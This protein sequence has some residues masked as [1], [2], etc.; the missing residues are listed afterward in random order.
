MSVSEESVDVVTD[1]GSQNIQ[2]ILLRLDLL[3]GSINR[4]LSFAEKIPDNTNTD[5]IETRLNRLDEVWKEFTN[6]T[7][8]LY[9]FKNEK[10]YVDPKDDYYEYEDLYMSA[11]CLLKSAQSKQTDSKKIVDKQAVLIEQLLDRL[12]KLES[13]GNSRRPSREENDFPK[14]V[15]KPF[16]G[17]YNEWPSFETLFTSALETK[18]EWTNI[19]KLKYLK[20][21]LR[22]DAA[23]AIQDIQDSEKSFDIAWKS[24]KQTFHRPRFIANTYIQQF[25]NIPV[26]KKPNSN[27]IRNICGIAGDVLRALDSIGE[28]D[29]DP[30]LIYILLSRLHS[31]LHPKWIEHSS[32]DLKP[33]LASFLIFL[34][35]FS[36]DLDSENYY[37][38]Q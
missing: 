13:S 37:S 4:I 8:E 25:M 6:Y 20:T 17:N 38:K 35:E 27:D 29:R 16:D 2:S 33:T 22:G 15:I 10:D 14:I 1:S 5:L 28:T 18:P 36:N 9:G 23:K 19:Q 24:L 32:K 7:E 21:L 31:D 26:M 30:W 34:D 12:Q 3:K 11:Q